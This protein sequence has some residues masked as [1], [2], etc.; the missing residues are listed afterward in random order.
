MDHGKFNF[1]N[2]CPIHISFCVL[3]TVV[4]WVKAKFVENAPY[5]V[6]TVERFY[7]HQVNI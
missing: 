7:V 1:L 5:D 2:R 4:V 6:G 3:L